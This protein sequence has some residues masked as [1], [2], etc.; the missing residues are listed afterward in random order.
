LC[1]LGGLNGCAD[2]QG[3]FTFPGISNTISAMKNTLILHG[4]F[5]QPPRENPDTGIIPIQSS[6]YPKDNWNVRIT[7]ECYSA[8]A[9]SRY[10]SYDGRIERIFNNYEHL[11]FNFGPTL[12]HWLRE[13]REDVYG[14]ILE[15]DRVSC[16]RF[17]G[18]GNAIA[19]SFNHTILPLDDPRD[20]ALQVSWGLDDFRFHFSRDAEGIWLPETAVNETVLDILIDQG[21]S[22]IVLSPWQA[23]RV[24]TEPGKWR[25][26]GK[27][28]APCTQPY[29]LARPKG[30]IAVFF[31]H[32]GLAEGISFGHFLRDAD[33][34]YTHIRELIAGGQTPLLHAAT[35]GE[36]YGHHEPFGDMCLAALAQRIMQDDEISFGNYG[37]YLAEH[38]PTLHAEL[39]KG[40]QH[41]G[42]SWSCFH[43]VSR[44]FKDCGCSTG[45]EHGWNQKWRAPLRSAFQ[46]ISH[47]LVSI[48]ESQ[49]SGLTDIGPW[50][51][52]SNYGR[53]LSGAQ[54][55]EAFCTEVLG[56]EEDQQQTVLLTLL[57]GQRF[58]HYMFT[59]CGW[60]FADISGIEPQQNMHYALHAVSLYQQ[61]TGRQLRHTLEDLLHPAKSNVKSAGRGSK[62]LR[63]IADVML[64]LG[65]EAAS[66]F[67][68][69]RELSR[70]EDRLQHYGD[71]ELLDSKKSSLGGLVQ[72]LRKGSTRQEY[73][74]TVVT[75]F[76]RIE[77]VLMHCREEVPGDGPFREITMDMLGSY[78][79]SQL[80]AWIDRSLERVTDNDLEQ[81][82]HDM[83]YYTGISKQSSYQP[84]QHFFIANMGTCMRTLNSLF[85][86][87]VIGKNR[88]DFELI[89]A[90]LDFIFQRGGT[91]E[92]ETTNRIISS[93]ML[94]L[95]SEILAATDPELF[96]FVKDLLVLTRESGFVPDITRLQNS[97][98]ERLLHCS[99]LGSVPCK[100]LK[101]LAM[102][103][104]IV[105]DSF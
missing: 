47:E 51:L 67:V 1:Q 57:E 102:Q 88:S 3:H 69:N 21:V 54:T 72:K 76:D 14:K 78:L 9:Y 23:Q 45:G 43:G 96:T 82:Y 27:H 7:D 99:D 36:I 93:Y 104:G 13:H 26:L 49:L 55:P 40:E 8:N 48:F 39:R 60:F 24:E 92:R 28:P 33:M 84:D 91:G 25:D 80:Y 61:L 103:A 105:T 19:Q 74:F 37:S 46:Q 17:N 5:Y 71:Y 94:Q 4:H 41:L 89:Q 29:L 56:S 31:Y 15:A 95:T 85:R 38:P 97:I 63:S 6:A 20:A 11:S 73:T 59:S 81:I 79:C 62:I 50:E 16:S 42:T 44:W 77:G 66:F 22:F 34:L 100:N 83:T 35:D 52:L 90:L 98:Y 65:V 10:L 87:G 2:L 75:E 70:S 86:L 64:P 18:H 58:R 101:E 30:N 32:P 12:L 53:V 68:L